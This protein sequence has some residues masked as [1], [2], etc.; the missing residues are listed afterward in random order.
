MAYSLQDF[1]VDAKILLNTKPGDQARAAIAE[2]LK[3][4]LVEPSFV[5]AHFN[6]A[7]Q[8]AQRVVYADPELGFNVLAHHQRPGRRGQP[9]DHGESWAIYGVARGYTVMTEWRRLD[10]GSQPGRAELEPTNT[11]RL[12]V[13]QSAAY[14]PRVIHNTHHPEGAWVVRITGCDLD[15]IRRLRFNPE[16]REVRAFSAATAPAM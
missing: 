11:Y 3:D 16:K 5:A 14:G 7:T 10:D 2:R 4:L 8:E 12:D 9:H 6:E 15:N 1:C 13:G